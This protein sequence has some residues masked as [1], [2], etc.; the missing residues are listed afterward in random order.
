MQ[1][2]KPEKT[3]EEEVRAHNLALRETVSKREISV[4]EANQF[5]YQMHRLETHE[6][7]KLLKSGPDVRQFTKFC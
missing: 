1:H 5:I 3:T 2:L 6:M 7:V 4:E